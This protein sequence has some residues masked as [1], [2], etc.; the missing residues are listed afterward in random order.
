MAGNIGVDAFVCLTISAIVVCL[1]ALI[2]PR[3][4]VCLSLSVTNDDYLPLLSGFTCLTLSLSV[5][6]D[7]V[8]SPFLH[9]LTFLSVFQDK[10][11][12]ET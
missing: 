10:K 8:L 4:V 6:L 5:S 12:S 2:S 7:V 3:L 1:A 11:N 9:L